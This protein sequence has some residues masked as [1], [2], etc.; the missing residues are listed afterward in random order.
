MANDDDIFQIRVSG[1]NANGTQ[2]YHNLLKVKVDGD[3]N[4][5][6]LDQKLGFL[7][8]RVVIRSSGNVGIGTSDPS[9]KLTIDGG[10]IKLNGRRGIGF[11][12]ETPY[13][14]DVSGDRAKIYYN[15]SFIG[16]AGDYLVF[17]KTDGNSVDPDGGI[18]FTNKGND[19]NSE[20]ALLIR[21]DGNIGIGTAV[22]QSKL[23]V[24][25]FVNAQGLRLT[26]ASGTPYAENWIGMANNMGDKG[27]KWLH[28]GGII[29][30]DGIRRSTYWADKHYFNGNVGI[31]TTAPEE[32]LHVAGNIVCTGTLQESDVRWKENLEPIDNALDLVTQLRGVFFDWTDASRGEGHQIGVIAQEVE[33]VLPEVVHTD[34]QGYK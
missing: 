1:T 2:T 9:E 32:K 4:G 5:D 30:S 3:P 22:P 10:G 24:L 20:V 23:D 25:G 16:D 6:I 13:I 26:D 29:D 21:G 27:K 17:E 18:V 33:Q 31:G 15:T 28:I 14:S 19:N 11:Y 34:S 7:D 8:D 12:G